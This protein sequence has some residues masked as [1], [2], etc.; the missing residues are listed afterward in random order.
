MAE[1]EQSDEEAPERIPEGPDNNRDV[2]MSQAQVEAVLEGLEDPWK[3]RKEMLMDRYA[4]Q[5]PEWHSFLQQY[6]K[7]QN[8][9]PTTSYGCFLFVMVERMSFSC[10]LNMNV[11]LHGVGRSEHFC[12]V[13][14]MN[15]C[16]MNWC[17]N[18]TD[19]GQLSTWRM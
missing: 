14:V 18:F 4:K 12:S 7:I 10:R 2:Y 16:R 3:E 11:V 13:S 15:G 9:V 1:D 8:E 6:V 19:I 5:F 17:G